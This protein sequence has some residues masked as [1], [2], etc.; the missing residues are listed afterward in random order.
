MKLHPDLESRFWRMVNDIGTDHAALIC[1]LGRRTIF[2]WL[3]DQARPTPGSVSLIA[4]GV[5]RYERSLATKPAPQPGSMYLME[6]A[7][8]VTA[9]PAS[10]C[11]CSNSP[12]AS[13]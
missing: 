7:L 13:S 3:A 1:H 10:L 12:G 11:R 2:R 9:E 6:R 5:R 4:L 8:P